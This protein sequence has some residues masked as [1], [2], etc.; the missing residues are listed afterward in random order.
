MAETHKTPKM[1]DYIGDAVYASWDGH[2]V[3]LDTRASPV[4]HVIY[5]DLYTLGALLRF[6]RRVGID[7]DKLPGGK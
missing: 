6:A 1:Q 2:Q 4:V 3:K 7:L 5:L